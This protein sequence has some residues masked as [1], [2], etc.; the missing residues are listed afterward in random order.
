MG[1]QVDA[2]ADIY[3]FG[4]VMWEIIT[5]NPLFPHHDNYNTFKKAIVLDNERPP[6]P[7]TIHPALRKLMEDW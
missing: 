2:K 4:L 5:G 6:I 3:S 7:D 1:K